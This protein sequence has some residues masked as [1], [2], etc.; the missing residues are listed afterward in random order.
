MD[1]GIFG[2]FKVV[3]EG[4]NQNILYSTGYQK[5]LLLNQGLDF[6]GGG[7]GSDIMSMCGVGG[8]KN[9]PTE[10]ETSLG[11]FLMSAEGSQVSSGYKYNPLVDK[12]FKSF[13]ECV[14]TY[15]FSKTTTVS[16]LG[17]ISLGGT[18]SNY[19]LCTRALIRDEFGVVKP[20][21][22]KV[23]ETLK[24][25]YRLYLVLDTAESS[26]IINITDRGDIVPYE[27]RKKLSYAGDRY[28]PDY[29]VGYP[30]DSPK[31]DFSNRFEYFSGDLGLETHIPDG[32]M[33]SSSDYI[34]DSYVSGS[35]SRSFS[36]TFDSSINPQPVRSFRLFSPMG[37]WQ[38]R[39]GSTTGDLPLT[40]YS[41]GTVTMTL[42]VT[43]GRHTEL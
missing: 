21:D 27:V 17:L 29:I 30:V 1:I 16:E 25:Y 32:K 35:Y 4:E 5:N 40:K 22:V 42:K 38:F 2:E 31:Y 3:V 20:L 41:S 9:Q 12:N 39:F 7:K 13:R 24:I 6:F 33:G 11:V 43:W 26:N 36:L 8:G 14:Y 23:G 19:Y 15:S 18:V 28:Y 34:L 10:D 37:Y